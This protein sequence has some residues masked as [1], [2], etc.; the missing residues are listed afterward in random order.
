MA[1]LVSFSTSMHLPTKTLNP[2]TS[3]LGSAALRCPD[4]GPIEMA[5]SVACSHSDSRSR[6]GPRTPGGLNSVQRNEPTRSSTPGCATPR[7][8]HRLTASPRR[9]TAAAAHAAAV[10]RGGLPGA[11][12]VPHRLAL[13]PHPDR[14][15]PGPGSRRHRR[16]LSARPGPAP[17]RSLEAGRPAG[18]GRRGALLI[19]AVLHA[20]APPD[21]I[22]A[23]AAVGNPLASESP[24]QGGV[25]IIQGGS[26]AAAPLQLAAAAD[27]SFEEK[28]GS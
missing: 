2:P 7:R 22:S 16:R 4:W 1:A 26:E 9:H 27:V 3:A 8:G 23:R 15:I 21:R 10:R 28:H 17:C 19:L 6:A 13:R 20:P 24:V 11:G 25:S 5:S 12:A 14:R 18:R